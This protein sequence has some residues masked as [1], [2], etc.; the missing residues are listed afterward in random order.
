MY[1]SKIFRAKM[2]FICLLYKLNSA[3]LKTNKQ[4]TIF[5]CV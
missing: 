2:D 3:D 5:L 1:S 4:G